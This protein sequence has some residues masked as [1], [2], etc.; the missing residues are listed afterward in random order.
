MSITALE[1]GSRQKLQIPHMF[2]NKD[3]V[4]LCGKR[5]LLQMQ[6]HAKATSHLM[7][8]VSILHFNTCKKENERKHVIMGNLSDVECV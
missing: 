5:Y 1:A 4:S 7:L 8:V 2:A 6:E 3:H